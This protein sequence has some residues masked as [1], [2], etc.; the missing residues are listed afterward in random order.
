MLGLGALSAKPFSASPLIKLLHSTYCTCCCTFSICSTAPPPPLTGN[1][2]VHFTHS[3]VHSAA[4]SLALPVAALTSSRSE[5]NTKNDDSTSILL[6]A[7]IL[8]Q[9]IEFLFRRIVRELLLLL[10]LPPEALATGQR[11][12]QASVEEVL[13]TLR[14]HQPS[15][16]PSSLLPGQAVSAAAVESRFPRLHTQDK[17]FDRLNRPP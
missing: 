12:L 7:V 11:L 8:P 6:R 9:A 16:P 1:S 4:L 10:L 2:R 5:L 14:Q 15:S 17:A 3:T 13:Q